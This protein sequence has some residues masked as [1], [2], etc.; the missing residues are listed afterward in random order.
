MNKIK[1]LL[2]VMVFAIFANLKVTGDNNNRVKVRIKDV[3]RLAGTENYTLVGYGIMI[4]LN[5]TGDSDAALIQRTVA[6]MLQN[7][8][9]KVSES[10]IKAQNCAAVMVTAV[11]KNSAHKGDVV[12][13][14]NVSSVGDAKSLT[15][16]TLILTPLLGP[17]AKLWATAQ[18]PVTT[19]GYSYGSDD[20]G[21]NAVVKNHP[22]AGMLTNGAKLIKDVNINTERRDIITYYL[23]NPD[24]TTA[25][26]FANEVNKKYNASTVANNASTIAIRVPTKYKEEGLITSFISKIEQLTFSV[27]S[28]ARIVFNSRTGTIVIGSNVKISEVAVNH[29]NLLVDIKKIDAVVTAAPFKGDAIAERTNNE[30]TDVEEPDSKFFRIPNTTTT[31]D[32]VRVLNALGVK[33]R[34][35]MIIFHALREAGALH[36]KLESI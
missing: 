18:G 26:N 29:G 28:E 8:N 3:A 31:G 6:N 23:N 13:T 16:G 5:G 21:G 35:I 4:G 7:F 17:D 32:L 10:E 24:Y 19:G 33:S 9:I 1:I 25:V 36:A 12:N 22:T 11:I 15:G 30:S 20:T 34:D 14:T 27:D 2:M